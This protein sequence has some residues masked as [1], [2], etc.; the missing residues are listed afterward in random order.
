MKEFLHM[1]RPAKDEARE[2][3][4]NSALTQ[5]TRSPA[6]VVPTRWANR[7]LRI[8]KLPLLSLCFL[9]SHSVARQVLFQKG[10]NQ[11]SVLPRA[12]TDQHEESSAL[13]SHHP[14]RP[15]R[16]SLLRHAQRVGVW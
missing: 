2:E 7:D 13:S 5:F 1:T 16:P 4:I 14:S 6:E 9:T 10:C 3:R 11:Q 15:R 8:G 12:D